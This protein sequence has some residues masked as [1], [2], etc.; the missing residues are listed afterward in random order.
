M[1]FWHINYQHK[2][3]P[4]LDALLQAGFVLDKDNPDF[5]MIDR[6]RY[7]VKNQSPRDD[8]KYYQDVPIIIYPHCSLPHWWYDGLVPVVNTIKG[9]FVIGEGQK[10]AMNIITPNTTIG[11]T[12]WAWSRILPFQPTNVKKV[13]F[14]PIH[15]TGGRLRPEAL[16][17]NEEIFHELKR[18]DFDVTIRHIGNI[19]RQGI[20]IP[21]KFKMIA[22]GLDGSTNEIDEADLVIAEGTFMYLAVARG[23]PV[24][25]IN[26]H[27]P[28]RPN[29]REGYFP[30]NWD[31]YGDSIAYPV[32]FG[33]K[34]LVDLIEDAMV[35]PVQWKKD[36]IGDEM[37]PA[38]FAAKVERILHERK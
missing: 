9:I 17:A 36:F 20:R 22:G 7:M 23:K 33:N 10:R 18:H 31:K 8:V 2:G 16:R 32:N 3:R 38:E 1:K 6:E 26:Q 13:L 14:A 27:L 21:N 30:R 28:M 25:G 5:L 29:V 37:N 35:E 19:R 34:P 11:T 24:I 4:Y 12:G 15:P